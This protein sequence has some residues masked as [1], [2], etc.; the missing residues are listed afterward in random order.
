MYRNIGIRIR[1]IHVDICMYREIYID[2]HRHV[3]M[4]V[5]GLQNP[6]LGYMLGALEMNNKRRPCLEFCYPQGW[7]GTRDQSC[8][9]FTLGI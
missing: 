2:L 7:G 9:R 1:I 3:C 6:S 5:A 4:Q 8:D